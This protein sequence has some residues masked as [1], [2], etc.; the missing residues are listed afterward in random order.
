MK[1]QEKIFECLVM[2]SAQEVKG[3]REAYEQ[4]IHNILSIIQQEVLECIGEDEKFID[5]EEIRKTRPYN[6][7]DMAL[8]QT[9]LGRN[10]LRSDIHSKLHEKGIV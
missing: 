10:Q 6:N 7:L 4:P 9:T 3:V 8:D 1:L 2:E 5:K